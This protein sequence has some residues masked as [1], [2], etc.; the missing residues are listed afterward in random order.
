[1]SSLIDYEETDI[2]NALKDLPS[3]EL[4]KIVEIL[5][6]ELKSREERNHCEF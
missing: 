4:K 3:K 1:M 2:I 6:E 5:V